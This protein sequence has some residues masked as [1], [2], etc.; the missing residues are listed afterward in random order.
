MAEGGDCVVEDMPQ[1]R[2]RE[3]VRRND[4]PRNNAQRLEAIER[5]PSDMQT[6]TYEK[7]QPRPKKQ[8]PQNGEGQG[9]RRNNNN[10][11]NNR[12]RGGNDRDRRK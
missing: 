3:A 2:P 10:N 8:K 5:K 4:R 9:E 12:R 1:R 6:G 7:P 11:N